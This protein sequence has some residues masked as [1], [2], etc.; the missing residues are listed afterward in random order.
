MLFGQSFLFVLF[1]KS[2][3]QANTNVVYPLVSVSEAHQR[4]IEIMHFSG[5]FSQTAKH[6]SKLYPLHTFFYSLP[7]DEFLSPERKVIFKSL[8][9]HANLSFW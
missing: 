1:F 6:G 7:H 8:E 9:P 4:K 5:T 3:A 2:Q